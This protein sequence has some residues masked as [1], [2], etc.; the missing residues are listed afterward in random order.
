[1]NLIDF[2]HLEK[3]LWIKCASY[4][5]KIV[6]RAISIWG[7]ALTCYDKFLGKSGAIEFSP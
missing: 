3:F 5:W 6:C 4:D 1:M 7:I 2:V